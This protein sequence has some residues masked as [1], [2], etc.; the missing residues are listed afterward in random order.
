MPEMN[1]YE[2]TKEIRKIN[3]TKRIPIIALTA[4]VRKEDKDSCFQAG[5]DDYISK[6]IV[7]NTIETMI[8]KWL[9]SVSV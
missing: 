3:T 2:A 9:F 7:K 8:K 5:M 1:G 4:G 6:P